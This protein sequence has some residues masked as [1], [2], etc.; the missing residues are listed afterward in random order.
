M[1][2]VITS[3]V[4]GLDCLLGGGVRKGAC[5]LLEGI[6]GVGKTTFGTQFIASG[7]AADEPGIIITFEQLPEQIYRDAGNLGWD[8]RDLELQDRLRVVC[9]SPEVF[10]DQLSDVG[11]M[12]DM[13]IAEIG[14]RRLMV[15]SVAHLTH[16]A[17][18]KRA[19]RPLVYG[20]LNGIRRAGLT[21][22]ITKEVESAS[23]TDIP[24]EEYL[25][26]TVI[27]LSYEL[28][29]DF[30]RRR[31]VEVVKSRGQHHSHGRH[32]VVID[33]C[34]VRIY[35]RYQTRQGSR[36]RAEAG[37]LTWVKSGVAGLDAM[38]CG[39]VPK[40]YCTLLAGS[41]GVGKTTL[42]LQFLNEGVQQDEPAVL[43]SFEE[44]PDKLTQL[45]NGFGIDLKQLQEEG[46]FDLMH[47]SPLQLSV[48]QL[49]CELQER[50]EAIGARR[51]VVDSLTDL[52]MSIADPRQFR[53]TV[54]MLSDAMQR[55][56]VTA[57]FTIEVPE[58]FGQTHVTSENISIIVDGI[59]LMKYV[60][61]ES[62]IQR[63]ISVLKM[64]GCD[65]D[66][67]IRRYTIDR[68]GI[69]VQSRFEGT[70]GVM[71]GRTT[72]TAITLSVRS[73]TEFDEALNN[74]LLARFSELHPQVRP[75]SLQIP[76]NPDEARGTIRGALEASTTS[77]SV[78]PLCLYWM[79]DL[80]ASGRLLPLDSVLS[81]R[82][83]NQH[84][85]EFVQPGRDHDHLYAVPA[86]S[87]CGV[88]LY[89][90]DLLEKYG[91]AT[92][93]TTWEELVHQAQTILGGEQD[94]EL[95]GCK[96]PGYKYEGLTT[97]FLQNLWSNGGDVL[98]GGRV[99]L[100]SPNALQAVQHMRDMIH[101]HHLTPSHVTTAAHGVE[102]QVA[103][104]EGRCI[105]LIMLPHLAQAAQRDGS[106]LRG[107]VGIA[108]HPMGPLGTE[109]VTF[110]GGW[111]YGIPVGARAPEAAANFIRFM[112]SYEIQRERSLRGGPMPTMEELFSDPEIVA[113]NP[114]YPLLRRLL[115]TARKRNDIPH[116]AEVSRLIQAH[117]HPVLTGDV[118]PEAALAKL[119]EEVELV[120]QEGRAK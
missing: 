50:V 24:F 51:V 9:T 68:H 80:I 44:S 90:K 45:A 16:V 88:L 64:R 53:Q 89:R 119:A 3:G 56:G 12:M 11:G 76:Y 46:K 79:Q 118:P 72:Q 112:T 8:L 22:M 48:D 40:G 21:A 106:P 42:A 10:L 117:L 17:D 114:D 27:R 49:V 111:H 28:D 26:D 96:F 37:A 120:Q 1:S 97:S 83:M 43:L 20:M 18:S 2:E 99:S 116:Y 61:M 34:G 84:L 62:E 75:V 15:D 55:A 104:R 23:P 67:G 38:L 101:R 33:D 4:P 39:G 66:K 29:S 14:A 113:F 102:P 109:S 41:A 81:A 100:D 57:L 73:F 108:P 58:L 63:A 32:S 98:T 70:S 87:L 105:F 71:A 19:L 5:V 25:V 94:S 59:I 103:F 95:V 54:F 47:R 115:R 74:Q 69:C 85:P 91:F 82:E 30:Y 35:P 7:A 13:L 52:T 92:P 78:V 65:H 110:L 36:P 86:M 77:L 6:P 60:E 107:K 93:P 31:Y